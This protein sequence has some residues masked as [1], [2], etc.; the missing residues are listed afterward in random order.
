[1]LSDIFFFFFSNVSAWVLC[2]RARVCVCVCLCV[3][4]CHGHQTNPQMDRGGEVSSHHQKTVWRT[5]LRLSVFL[6]PHNW[7]PFTEHHID[8]ELS[9]HWVE[10]KGFFFIFI[11]QAPL[12]WVFSF[13]DMW[14]IPEIFGSRAFEHPPCPIHPNPPHCTR[15][16]RTQ[17]T[18]SG[19]KWDTG[20]SRVGSSSASR[21]EV[22]YG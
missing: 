7:R 19:V 11:F 3:R 22:D 18:F 21:S 6:W 20:T 17:L 9:S 15:A 10:N 14:Q 8:T 2:V 16:A 5:F 13:W 12:Y 1:M 4:A